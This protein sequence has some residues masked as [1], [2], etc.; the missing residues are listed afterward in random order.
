MSVICLFAGV[1]EPLAAGYL[2]HRTDSS[3]RA[4][5]GSFQSLGENAVHVGIGLGFGY[6]SSKF[7]IFGGYGFIAVVCSLF[8]VY[9]VSAS[10]KVV[11]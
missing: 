11:E 3:M 7:D 6:L 9:F 4:T 2:H 1:M 5:I 8:F 10:R